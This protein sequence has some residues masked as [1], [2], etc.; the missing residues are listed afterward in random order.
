MASM[1][2]QLLSRYAR[3]LYRIQVTRLSALPCL[4]FHLP[5]RT[6]IALKTPHP[7]H[8]SGSAK[9][10]NIGRN[11]PLFIT[12]GWAVSSPQIRLDSLTHISGHYK[13]GVRRSARG[14]T[15]AEHWSL[16][17]LKEATVLDGFVWLASVHP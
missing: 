5:R 12:W 11:R 14:V 1:V 10:L 9:V 15:P 17:S 8:V 4:V 16:V 3:R 2:D 13:K 6:V 7:D